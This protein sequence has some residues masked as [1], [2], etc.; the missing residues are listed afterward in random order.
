MDLALRSYQ[1]LPEHCVL[2]QEGGTSADEVSD[3][4]EAEPQEV[5]HPRVI[6]RLARGRSL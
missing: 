1:L 4:S 3:R 5:D 2:R 6:A